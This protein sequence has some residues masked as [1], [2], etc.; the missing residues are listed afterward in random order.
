MLLSTLHFGDIEIVEDQIIDIENGLRGFDDLKRFVI[1]NNN[2]TEDPVPFMWLQSVEDPNVAFV[3]T[4]PFFFE[5]EYDV[6][7]PSFIEKS[8]HID[9][10]EDVAVYT[11]VN[12][13]EDFEKS[14]VNLMSPIFIN[15]KTK[16]GRQVVLYDSKFSNHKR[17]KE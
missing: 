16:K 1:L 14:T 9:S 10:A 11:I 2:D 5:P 7:I 17:F 12:V 4:I 6:D 8:M 13:N 3:L 15:T